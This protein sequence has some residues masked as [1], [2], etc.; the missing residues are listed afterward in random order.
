MLLIDGNFLEERCKRRISDEWNKKAAPS[1][2]ADAYEQF[3]TDI[4]NC[5]PVD[6]VPVVRCRECK[7]L[8]VRSGALGVYQC[9]IHGDYPSGEY[10]CAD[11]KRKGGGE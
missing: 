2:W 7:H 11:G 10:Y 9:A 1:S 4:E 6:A 5:P 3:L 8:F